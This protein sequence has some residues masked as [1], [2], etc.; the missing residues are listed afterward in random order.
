MEDAPQP[1]YE[2][3]HIPC[4]SNQKCP[5]RIK[6]RSQGLT[7]PPSMAKQAGFHPLVLSKA[8]TI[9]LTMLKCSTSK[10]GS[11]LTLHILLPILA[12]EIIE[13]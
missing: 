8:N 4:Y 13:L 2:A 1:H 11:S 9:L 12:I 5:S 10:F 7:T 6:A 3:W